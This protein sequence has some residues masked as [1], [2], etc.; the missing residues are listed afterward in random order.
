MFP[1]GERAL[2]D[3]LPPQQQ[4]AVRRSLARTRGSSPAPPPRDLSPE[5][6]ASR[7][8]AARA[9]P[10]ALWDRVLEALEGLVNPHSFATWFRPTSGLGV[11]PEG[12]ALVVLV[13]NP[14]F[15]TWLL[16]NYRPPIDQA[17]AA[18]GAEG[19]GLV[20]VTEDEVSE[21]RARC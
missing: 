20:L 3:Q 7:A 9:V 10:C 14:N 18:A 13:P 15:R 12:G 1:V 17:M 16:N 4:E 8:A 11:D 21:G 19:V 2:I 6:V 5:A